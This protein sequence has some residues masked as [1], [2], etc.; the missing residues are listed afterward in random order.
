M[1]V[2][3]VVVVLVPVLVLGSSDECSQNVGVMQGL[4]RD[5]LAR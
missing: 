1:V 5:P 4:L 2:V 3:V